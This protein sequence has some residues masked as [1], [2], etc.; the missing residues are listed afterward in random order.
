LSDKK[1]SN[2]YI[3]MKPKLLKDFEEMGRLTREAGKAY[4]DD[5]TLDEVIDE[6]KEVFENLIPQIPYV[7]GRKNRFSDILPKSTMSLA[8]YKVL[9]ARGMPLEEIGRLNYAIAEQYSKH[10]PRLLKILQPLLSRL[11]FSPIIK[12][13]FKKTA[14]K[15]Q[16]R[17]YADDWV[18]FYVKEDAEQFDLGIDFTDCA[19]CKFFH[20]QGADEFTKYM[21]LTD[22]A[23]GREKGSGLFRTTTLAEGAEKCDFRWKKGGDVKSGWPPPWLQE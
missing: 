20:Q 2:Y 7:G 14:E 5:A 3:S 9:K 15:S 12:R 22:F 8:L 13:M 21:C 10:V 11:R 6:T 1:H 23:T 19:I 18:L 4:F 16:K 17:E